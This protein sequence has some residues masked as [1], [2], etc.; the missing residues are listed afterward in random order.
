MT[1]T[2]HKHVAMCRGQLYQHIQRQRAILQV[3]TI[4]IY[5][6]IN[7]LIY[8]SMRM[9]YVC[10]HEIVVILRIGISMEAFHS[11]T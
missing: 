9:I 4:Y 1:T 3:I 2:V 6:I 7:I 11:K 8:M 10:T 5:T